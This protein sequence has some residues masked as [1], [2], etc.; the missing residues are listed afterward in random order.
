MSVSKIRVLLPDDKCIEKQ[1][2]NLAEFLPLIR[3]VNVVSYEAASY[4]IASIE[5]IIDEDIWLLV[6]LE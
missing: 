6:I 3:M 2:S 1:V 5:L 4:R